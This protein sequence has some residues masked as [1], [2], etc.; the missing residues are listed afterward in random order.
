MKLKIRNVGPNDYGSYRCVA[1]NSLGETDGLIKLE[2]TFVP[3]RLNWNDLCD[4][5]YFP[6][7]FKSIEFNHFIFPDIKTELIA[8]TTV[9]TTEHYMENGRKSKDSQMVGDYGVEEWRDGGKCCCFCQW[10]RKKNGKFLDILSWKICFRWIHRP[11]TAVDHGHAF[12]I[13]FFWNKKFFENF[14]LKRQNE[15]H[16]N[17]NATTLTTI[18]T[19]DSI[20]LIQMWNSACQSFS[21][22]FIF[23]LVA[24]QLP[25]L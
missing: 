13:V 2:G 7:R 22:H 19:C 6:T 18:P 9:K 11:C 21:S 12:S 16:W 14:P 10:I 24:F 5:K 17:W 3:I 25:T 23:M 20:K 8:P 15:F 4:L 1:K